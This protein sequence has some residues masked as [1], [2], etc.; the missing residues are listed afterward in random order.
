MTERTGGGRRAWR[1]R[2]GILAGLLAGTVALAAGCNPAMLALLVLPWVDD[3]EPA[4]FP[5]ADP[6]REVKVVIVSNFAMA[7]TAAEL[8]A[9]DYLLSQKLAQVLENQFKQNKEKVTIIAPSRVQAYLRDHPRWLEGPRQVI[10]DKFQADYV[11]SLEINRFSL[12]RPQDRNLLQG[13]AEIAVTVTDVHKPVGEGEKYSRT[14]TWTYPVQP[15]DEWDTNPPLF[16]A[17]FVE[18]IARELCWLFAAHPPRDRF[19]G[20]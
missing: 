10:G 11:I 19:A 13:N 9:V 7:Q 16:R 5:L 15:R 14:M 4:D 3:K 2:A 6:D 20:E 17:Q 8:Q 12:R 1:W 18:K